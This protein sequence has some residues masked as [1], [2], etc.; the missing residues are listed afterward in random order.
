[1]KMSWYMT[2]ILCESSIFVDF[3]NM[4]QEIEPDLKLSRQVYVSV[5]V[6]DLEFRYYRFFKLRYCR[7]FL[8]VVA[9]QAC[10]AT[11]L[12]LLGGLLQPRDPT[13]AVPMTGESVCILSK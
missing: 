12:A 8:Q 4:I 9:T 11:R 5:C 10:Q 7:R 13:L 1:M 2:F 3:S 6:Y